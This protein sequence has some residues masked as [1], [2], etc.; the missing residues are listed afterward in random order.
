MCVNIFHPQILQA[1]AVKGLI[2]IYIC[3]RRQRY[4]RHHFLN[5]VFVLGV[6]GLSTY[7]C[8][9]LSRNLIHAQQCVSVWYAC[10]VIIMLCFSHENS[11]MFDSVCQYGTPVK[12]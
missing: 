12:L 11:Y 7:I 3:Y 8:F 5:A 2:L 9:C 1:V 10:T 6:C 4:K